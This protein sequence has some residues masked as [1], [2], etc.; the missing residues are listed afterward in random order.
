MT[1]RRALEVIDST[2]TAEALNTPRRAQVEAPAPRRAT[3]ELDYETTCTARRRLAEVPT[4]VETIDFEPAVTPVAASAAPA[5]AFQLPPAQTVT[6]RRP[7][8]KFALGVSMAAMIGSVSAGALISRSASSDVSSQ[9]V[10]EAERDSS[11]ISRSAERA[12]LAATLAASGGAAALSDTAAVGN[13][14]FS[15]AAGMSSQQL[16]IGEVIP[17]AKSFDPSA[18]IAP[19][20]LTPQTV[21][22]AMATAK[23]MVGDQGYGNMCLALVSKFYGYSTAGTVGAQQAAEAI[24]AAGQMHTD[25]KDIPVGALIWYDGTPIGNPYGH[26][27]MYAG[28]GMV[29]SNGAPTGVGLIPLEEPATGWKEPIMGWSAVWLPAATK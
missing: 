23:S 27:A 20:Q 3:F 25:M 1:A 5:R 15:E 2:L 21:E 10:L 18:N 26:V 12:A 17:A 13:Q 16:A 14:S 9:M 11:Q 24:K 7:R 22:Q 4:D 6:K 28:D 29:Y 19:G 8:R